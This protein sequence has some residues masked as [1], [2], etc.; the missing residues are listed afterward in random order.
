MDTLH[1]QAGQRKILHM[2]GQFDRALCMH[3]GGRCVWPDDMDTT[4][5]CPACG[6]AGGMRPDVVWFQEKPYH[7][8]EIK[9]LLASCDLYCAIGTSSEVWPAAGYVNDAA[10]KGAMTLEVNPQITA[11]SIYFDER[12]G[13]PASEAVPRLVRMLGIPA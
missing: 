11:R 6:E 1:E 3:C 9:D 13:G 4:T 7:L 2:H 5:V 10:R 8:D 12:L